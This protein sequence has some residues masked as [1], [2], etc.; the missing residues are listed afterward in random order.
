[1]K[2]MHVIHYI[3]LAIILCAG[4]AAFYWARPDAALQF[5]VGVV[6]SVSYVAWG[7]IHHALQKDLHQKIVVEYILI[8]A[9]AIILLATVLRT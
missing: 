1:M 6:V 9:I 5:I 8:G 7:L 3:V 4:L 2:R